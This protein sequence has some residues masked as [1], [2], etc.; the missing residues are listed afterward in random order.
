M[1]EELPLLATS[2]SGDSL[3]TELNS[4]EEREK[5]AA[6]AEK[7]TFHHNLAAAYEK[8]VSWYL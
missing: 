8:L 6:V 5:L 4:D 2:A 3:S 1:I 7:A